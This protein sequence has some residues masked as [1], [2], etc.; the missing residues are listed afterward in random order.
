[1]SGHDPKGSDRSSHRRF[2]L[3]GSPGADER[4]GFG[5][6]W[7]DPGARRRGPDLDSPSSPYGSRDWDQAAR[8]DEDDAAETPTRRRRGAGEP[9]PYPRHQVAALG[10]KTRVVRD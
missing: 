7:S 9:S 4:R 5:A 2:E 6:H 1:M 3:Y 10:S 8:E